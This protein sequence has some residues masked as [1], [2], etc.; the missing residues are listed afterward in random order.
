MPSCVDGWRG[1]NSKYMQIRL[2]I[3]LEVENVLLLSP[4]SVNNLT[5]SQVGVEHIL[6]ALQSSQCDVTVY[7]KSLS[8]VSSNFSAFGFATGVFGAFSIALSTSTGTVVGK[9]NYSEP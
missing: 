4:C 7:V 2:K 5:K 6:L 9:M 8:L 3:I 1:S